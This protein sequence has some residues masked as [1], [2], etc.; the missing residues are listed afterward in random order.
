[1]SQYL[2]RAVIAYDGKTLDA[3]P[4]ASIDLGGIARKPVNTMYQTGYSEERKHAVVECEIPVSK[5]TPDAEIAAIVNATVT[6]RADTGQTWMVRN[7]FCEDT[8]KL[9]AKDGGGMK[10]K[11]AG[12]PAERV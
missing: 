11:L 7:A 6:F 3:M 9:S 4:G 5:D 8:L 1:M 2:G 12:D 10:L